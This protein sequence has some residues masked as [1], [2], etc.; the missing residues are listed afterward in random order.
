MEALFHRLVRKENR[1]IKEKR[2]EKGNVSYKEEQLGVQRKGFFHAGCSR[3]ACKLV[4][5]PVVKKR[6]CGGAE[7][8]QYPKRGVPSWA[9]M[10]RTGG[11]WQN[12]HVPRERKAVRVLRTGRAAFWVFGISWEP[13]PPWLGL[14]AAALSLAAATNSRSEQWKKQTPMRCRLPSNLTQDMRFR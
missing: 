5:V 2:K 13:R 4:R 14:L 11:I 12:Y 1:K 8:Y 9:C 6:A 3:H 7:L 10:L